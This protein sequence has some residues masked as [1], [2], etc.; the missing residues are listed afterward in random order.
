MEISRCLSALPSGGGCDLWMLVRLKGARRAVCFRQECGRLLRRLGRHGSGP[1]EYGSSDW[2]GCL[3]VSMDG[4][5][6]M[7]DRNNSR[8]NRWKSDGTLLPSIPLRFIVSGI[9]PYL[10]P[11]SDQSIY[12]RV[13]FTHPKTS[14]PLDDPSAYGFVHLGSQGNVIDSVPFRHSW[15]RSPTHRVF[16]PSEYFQPLA[17]GRLLM[18]GGDRLAFLIHG[19]NKNLMV[20]EHQVPRVVVSPEERKEQQATMDWFSIQYHHGSQPPQGIA[21]FKPATSAMIVD[22]EMRIWLWRHVA[23]VQGPPHPWVTGKFATPPPLVREVEPPVFAAFRTDGTYL[24]EV[25]LPQLGPTFPLIYT[26]LI[27]F[28]GDTIWLATHA[29]DGTPILV[30]MAHCEHRQAL[31]IL[32]RPPPFNPRPSAPTNDRSRSSSRP[33]HA[34]RSSR[35]RH[36]TA[37]EGS[38]RRTWSGNWPLLKRSLARAE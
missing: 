2:L 8:V 33:R 3:A 36:E 37:P 23:A 34:S 30:K 29:E 16:D 1:G 35:S 32:S 6:L 25:V 4:T 17:D 11:G 38:P 24:G 21:E 19:P 14:N 12:V 28:I 15:L 5:I 7:Y 31:T 20:A 9:P 22:P 27:G 26:S 18:S 10:L 13:Q